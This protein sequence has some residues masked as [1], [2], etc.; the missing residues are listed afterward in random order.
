MRTHAGRQKKRE[1]HDMKFKSIPREDKIMILGVMMNTE[2]KRTLP[3]KWGLG[4]P[5]A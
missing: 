2:K 4:R 1:R 3:W 5:G